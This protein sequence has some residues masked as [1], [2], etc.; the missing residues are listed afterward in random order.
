M[1]YNMPLLKHPL[2]LITQDSDLQSFTFTMA[3]G[4]HANSA[5]FSKDHKCWEPG[6]VDS[7]YNV[8]IM[9]KWYLPGINIAV[10]LSYNRHREI[11]CND[12][13]LFF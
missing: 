11:V 1:N 5:G 3:L 13:L 4:E 6:L 7:I 9:F 10:S 8:V 12:L 2:N